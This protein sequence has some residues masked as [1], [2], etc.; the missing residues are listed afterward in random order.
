MIR[1]RVPKL[2]TILA[3][4]ACI[5]G[6]VLVAPTATES[7]PSISPVPTANA[8]PVGNGYDMTCTKAN[9]NQVNCVIAGC[10]RVYEDLAGDLHQLQDQRWGAKQHPEV[11]R[12]HHDG[13]RQLC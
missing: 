3:T 10:P 5:F 1:K 6:F 12:Q 8:V 11:V 7:L 2:L 13:D 4:A 9:D